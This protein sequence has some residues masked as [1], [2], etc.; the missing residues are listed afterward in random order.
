MAFAAVTMTSHYLRPH[1]LELSCWKGG[2]FYTR[3]QCGDVIVIT[4]LFKLQFLNK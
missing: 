1:H 2:V 4:E 3:L